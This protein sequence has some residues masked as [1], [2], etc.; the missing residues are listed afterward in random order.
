[1]NA[2]YRTFLTRVEASNP[3]RLLPSSQPNVRMEQ[4][5]RGLP[6]QALRVWAGS[7][8][9]KKWGQARNLVQTIGRSGGMADALDSKSSVLRDM[10][11]QLPPPVLQGRQGVRCFHGCPTQGPFSG[12]CCQKCCQ[13]RPRCRP[14]HVWPT[15]G[16]PLPPHPGQRSTQGWS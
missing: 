7:W 4:A 12:H 3:S 11:V 16:L 2:R 5:R 15:T 8:T 10:W 13:V 9:P 14:S 1:M 6:W